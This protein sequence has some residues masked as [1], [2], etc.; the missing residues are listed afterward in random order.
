MI[1]ILAN[2]EIIECSA[3]KNDFVGFVLEEICTFVRVAGEIEIVHGRAKKIP[4]VEVSGTVA[5]EEDVF[6]HHG[7][8]NMVDRLLQV[9]PSNVRANCPVRTAFVIGPIE[10]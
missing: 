6:F 10:R 5:Q 8:W 3:A 9:I 1:D 2:P 7:D 4:E